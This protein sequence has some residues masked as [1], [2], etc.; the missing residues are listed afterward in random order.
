MTPLGALAERNFRLLFLARTASLLGSAIAPVALAFAVL[1]ELGGSASD[2]GLVLTAA[3]VPQIVFLLVG[4]VWADRLPRNLVLVAT[5]L[6]M[7]GAQAAVAVLL[8]TDSAELWHLAVTQAVRGFAQ[9][10]FFPASTG[11]VPQTVSDA[12]LQEANALLRLSQSS[13]GVLGAAA[14]GVLVAAFGSAYA[15][16]FDALTFLASAL[17][18]TGIHLPRDATVPVRNFVRELKEGWDEFW[19]R[20]WLWVIVLAAM[21]NNAVA[22]G[23]FAVLGPVVADDALGGAK[24]WGAILAAF[25]AGF[26]VSGLVMLRWRPDR[27]L[28]VACAALLLFSPTLA[29]L[30]VE[31]N[32]LA[33]AAAA[34]FAGFGLE[35]FGVLWDTAMQQHV[36]RDRL[37]RVSAYDYLGSFVA[38]PIGLSIVGPLADRFGRTETLIGAALVITT[39]VVLQ[40]LVRDIRTMRRLET[41]PAAAVP[42]PSQ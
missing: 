16:A 36:P 3:T 29:L 23:A 10:F 7:F 11:L 37:S 17:L 27:P 41:E 19:S 1:D 32:V 30:A 6:T 40:F 34:F 5:D 20:T 21:V 8:L 35:V 14:G 15:I 18:L 2:L 31:A 13:L 22:Q 12:R 38:I 4:G 9:A 26:V 28:V 24:A 33:I 39:T 25:A 42:T